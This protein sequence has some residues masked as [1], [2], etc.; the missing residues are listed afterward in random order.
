V[1]VLFLYNGVYPGGMAMSNRIHLY[2]KSLLAA[3]VELELVVPSNEISPAKRF[4]EGVPYL[5]I[6]NPI[7]F[8]NYILR[9][10]NGFF[11]A[12]VYARFC[13]RC[14]KNY[15]ILF[16]SGF[17]W[18]TTM[19]AIIGA[20]L[21]GANVALEVNENPYSPEGGRLDIVFI[22]KIRRQLML[23]LP[24]RLADGFIVISGKLEELVN[25]Y[26]N[27]HAQIIKIPILVDKSD[28]SAYIPQKPD[29]PFVLHAGAL[30]E[31]KDGM[32]AVFKGY[33]KAY[34]QLGGSLQ[35]I[36]TQ[37]KMHPALSR[38]IN[39]IIKRN[40]I[41]GSIK[42]TGYLSKNELERLRRTCTTAVLNKPSNWQNDYN[43]S[44]R[45]G[46]YLISGIPTIVSETGEMS[47][48]LKDEVNAFMV[49][50]NDQ[51][52]IAE[53]IIHITTHPIIALKVGNAAR[54]LALKEFYYMNHA[55]KIKEF[56]RQ[57]AN[58]KNE[59]V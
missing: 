10:I 53:K 48:Y 58:E 13:Y 52:A 8:R 47:L 26:K 7:I 27:K 20:H 42:F 14:S 33:A 55:G 44:T 51:D 25:K 59:Y 5:T 57:L 16:I 32:I 12:F 2:G 6:K 1:K 18:F 56:Y 15:K 40:G 31:T 21:G 36:L 17:G 49:P 23:Q 29:V 3:G 28:E 39:K 30:S 54:Q 43:F 34:K 11:A 22:R 41:E 46:E 4:N 38:E 9:Q 35:F 45:L 37:K 50:A 19:L 24:F